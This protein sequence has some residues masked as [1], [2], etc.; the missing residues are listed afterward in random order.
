MAPWILRADEYFTRMH[1]LY[2]F[3]LRNMS[4][5]DL[6]PSSKNNISVGLGYTFDI[7]L[8]QNIMAL[9]QQCRISVLIKT[10]LGTHISWVEWMILLKKYYTFHLIRRISNLVKS[11]TTIIFINHCCIFSFLCVYW[12]SGESRCESSTWNVYV[13]YIYSM[14]LS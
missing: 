13:F 14:V 5:M 9:L 12:A 3:V 2:I 6:C 11:A 10:S 8:S 7:R 4:M 1:E